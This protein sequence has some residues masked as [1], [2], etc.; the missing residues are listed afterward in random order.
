[1]ENKAPSAVEVAVAQTGM[2]GGIF[3][4]TFPKV[5]CSLVCLC[6]IQS[7]R[8]SVHFLTIVQSSL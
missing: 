7:K 1:M 6:R 2:D 8:P 5:V 4:Y 3:T